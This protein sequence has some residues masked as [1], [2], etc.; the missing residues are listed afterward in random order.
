MSKL[1]AFNTIKTCPQLRYM[2]L[3]GNNNS[4][5]MLYQIANSKTHH[6]WGPH[7]R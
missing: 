5:V 2:R 6:L 7:G 3:L 4:N 1:R